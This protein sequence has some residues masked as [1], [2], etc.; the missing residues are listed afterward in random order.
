MTELK[1]RIR[2][3]LID[4]YEPFDGFESKERNWG[5]L[6]AYLM[7]YLASLYR[8]CEIARF[9]IT[10][11][12]TNNSSI[13]VKINAEVKVILPDMVPV[14]WRFGEEVYKEQIRDV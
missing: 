7:D 2:Q 14:V 8:G 11:D 13:N 1:E 5:M 6:R 12:S 3:E 9:E 4:I 10:C